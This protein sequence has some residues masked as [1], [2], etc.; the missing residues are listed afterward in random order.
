[1][2]IL[3]NLIKIFQPPMNKGRVDLV[4]RAYSKLDK[5]GDGQITF[6]DLKG[7]INLIFF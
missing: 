4:L 6:E 1:M 5:N 3:F 7:F 2:I